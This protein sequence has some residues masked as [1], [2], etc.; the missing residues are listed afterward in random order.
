MA[1]SS[2]NEKSKEMP[3]GDSRVS[4]PLSRNP[5][6]AA[7]ERSPLRPRASSDISDDKTVKSQDSGSVTVVLSAR[8][9]ALVSRLDSDYERALESV[10]V[11][12]AARYQS[13]RQSALCSIMFMTV[14]LVLG[15]IFFIKQAPGW[16]P[17][18]AV[19]FSLYTVTTVGYGHLAH[20]ETPAFQLYVVGYILVGIA[21]LTI[22]VAQI[23]QCIALEASRAHVAA[24]GRWRR[25][26][27]K[28]GLSTD[29]VFVDAS[30]EGSERGSRSS[31][32]C[33]SQLLD[34]LL[35]CVQKL[36]RY[37]RDDEL[38]RGISVIFPLSFLVAVGAIVI[39]VIEQWTVTES[40]Y[41]SICSLTTGKWQWQN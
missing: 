28:R 11:G 33:I 20:P 30:L 25:G 14:L 10:H 35:V 6:A 39:G 23:Y 40:L 31:S 24:D 19:L 9:L 32:D 36:Y 7:V 8:D 5:S 15:T 22:M 26:G 4:H 41:F 12:Y 2:E 13:V 18:E 29:G 38:G 17:Q 34:R 16:T 37:F 27:K 3:N 1:T 21:T